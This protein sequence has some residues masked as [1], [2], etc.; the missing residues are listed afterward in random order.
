MT[1]SFFLEEKLLG[2][3]ISIIY[4]DRSNATKVQVIQTIS[5]LVQNI[6]NEKALCRSFLFS[7]LCS[8]YPVEQPHQLDHH[9]SPGL[10]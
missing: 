6:R 2:D 7:S 3:I 10:P 5:I 8:L 4:Q 1:A 9:S